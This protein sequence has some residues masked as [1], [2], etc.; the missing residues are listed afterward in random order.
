MFFSNLIVYKFK[1][2]TAEVVDLD[3][4]ETALEQDKFTPCGEQQLNTMGWSN[5]FGR[6]GNTLAHANTDYVLLCIRREEK[7]IPAKA[8]NELVNNEIQ[9]IESK[10]SRPVKSKEKSEIKERVLF[11]MMP[12]AFTFSSYQYGLVDIKNGYLIVN[13]GSFNKAEEFAA[14]LRRSLGSLPIVPAFANIDLDIFLTSWVTDGALPDG[15]SLGGDADLEEP[16]DNGAQLKVKGHDLT[17]DEIKAHLESGKRVT[18]VSLD[19]YERIGFTLQN[20]GA[21]K[22]LSYSETIKEENADIPNEDMAAR[23][24]ADFILGA[25]E[26]T[27]LVN[28]LLSITE[29]KSDA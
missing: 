7:I 6:Y 20:D 19:L 28:A 15:F 5:A 27:E 17:S 1:K 18:K 9:L 14:L 23:L 8:I 11:Q 10:E 25:S 21:V 24:D 29:A 26:V 22:R 4:L 2:D 16:D 12:Q 3:K 13:S